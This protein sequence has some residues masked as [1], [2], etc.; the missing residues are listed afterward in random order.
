MKVYQPNRRNL[1]FNE[2][3]GNQLKYD[4][5]SC[6][7]LAIPSLASKYKLTALFR[8]YPVY[9]AYLWRRDFRCCVPS[10]HMAF[11]A[12][13]GIFMD[14]VDNKYKMVQVMLFLTLNSVGSSS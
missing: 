3:G 11:N 14:V 7:Y 6:P 12:K 4:V 9:R 13:L 2:A 8:S 10:M 1:H 5:F